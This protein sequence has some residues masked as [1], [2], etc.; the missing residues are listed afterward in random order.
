M[1][2][3]GMR[4]WVS[5]IALLAVFGLV[6]RC[7]PA[8]A[9]DTIQP[10]GAAVTILPTLVV[11]T[12]AVEETQPPAWQG[13]G[14][15]R[16]GV[17]DWQ[18]VTPEERGM[19]PD[20]LADL[21][22]A[23]KKE[24]IPLHSL[25]IIRGGAILSETYYSGYSANTRHTM[26]SVTKSFIS[27]LVG[28]AIDQGIIGSVKQKV[29]DLLPGRRWDHLDAAKRAMTLEDVLTMRSGLDWTEGDPAYQALYSSDNWVDA[30]MDAR[31][32]AP[33]GQWFNY[34]SGCSHLLSAIV[35]Q[36]TGEATQDFARRVLFKPL[37]IQGIAWEQDAQGIAIG[38]WGLELTPREMARLGYLF[39]HDG[40]WGGQPV[41]SRAWVRSATSAHA[42]T[43]T[44][45]QDFKYGY[46]WW[47]YPR[48]SAFLAMG[49]AGQTIFVA[50]DLDLI[51]VVTA[52][53]PTDHS[54][55]FHLIDDYI[56]PAVMD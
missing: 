32:V 41:V 42:L 21:Q 14:P 47:I 25:L 34:C 1:K 11:A 46:Q 18:T 10:N 31:M 2:N 35:Q 48:H 4:K 53:L 55:I 20:R 37:G 9:P 22:T 56:L 7:A 40:Q 38:G 26:Y 39:L 51:V 13:V 15:D 17:T 12:R 30:V 6:V 27:T 23:V 28:I 8:S 52:D 54:P 43:G 5:R 19:D 29:I 24:A 16:P 44:D 36:Q 45:S 49:S 3:K 50:P 33:P